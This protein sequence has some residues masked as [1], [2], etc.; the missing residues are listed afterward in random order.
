MEEAQK[1]HDAV[2][3]GGGGGGGGE[4]PGRPSTITETSERGSRPGTFAPAAADAAASTGKRARGG[5]GCAPLLLVFRRL[6]RS[7]RRPQA[8]P[9]QV[10][11]RYVP[12]PAATRATAKVAPAAPVD[13]RVPSS[14]AHTIRKKNVA[15]PC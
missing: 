8:P 9:P 1:I 14:V 11:A 15:G 4:E 2:F 13:T 7:R 12:S 10:A 6:L 3:G 5:G